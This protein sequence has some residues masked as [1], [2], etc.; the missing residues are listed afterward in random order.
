[1]H[2]LTTYLKNSLNELTKVVWLSRTQATR[3]TVAV[4]A[5]TLAI[6]A[7]IGVMDYLLTQVFQK[8]ILNI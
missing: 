5:F 3:Y 6:A 7:F 1:M 2:Q 8:L 4:L